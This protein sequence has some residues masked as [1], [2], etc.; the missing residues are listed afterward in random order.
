MRLLGVSAVLLVGAASAARAQH[1]VGLFSVAGGN[2]QIG[3]ID[4]TDGSVALLGSPIG[5]SA[6]SSASGVDS[7]DAAGNRF[8]FVGTPNLGSESIY[9]ID[10]ATGANAPGSPQVLGTPAVVGL[11]YDAGEGV[12]YGLFIVSGGNRQLGTINPA[13]GAVA[14]LGS[15]IGAAAISSASGVN[16]LDATGNRFFFVGTPNLGSE[17][18]FAIDTAT[19]ANTPGSP[20][21]LGTSAVVGLEY[22]AGEGALYGLFIVSGGNRQ[23]G[24]VNPANGAVA[25]LG[26]PIG[27]AAISSSSGVDALDAGGNRYFFPG[28]PNLGSE[29][30]YTVDT[31]TG[32]NA[33]NSPQVLATG[34]VLGL[35]YDSGALPVTLLK[36]DVE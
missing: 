8:F 22:D 26:S 13:T 27:A 30:I 4:P 23:L 31:A 14:L 19:G 5:A 18:I 1:L 35:E 33:P 12:L 29:S 6:I 3:E 11:E 25:L 28:T 10:T 36:F 9:A 34:I 32:G 16:S 20:Q 17:S 7:L 2:R 21:V 15:P 24:T